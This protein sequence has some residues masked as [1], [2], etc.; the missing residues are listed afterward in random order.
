MRSAHN[1][2]TSA[3][4]HAGAGAGSV[5]LAGC[6]DRRCPSTLRAHYARAKG[7]T[8][9]KVR[10]KTAAM[11]LA[12]SVVMALGS[13][14]IADAT[15]YGRVANHTYRTLTGAD[16]KEGAPSRCYTWNKNGGAT[17]S[18]RNFPCNRFRIAPRSTTSYRTDVDGFEV[19]YGAY[20]KIG[21]WGS[22]RWV[23]G[24][25]FTRIRD[26]EIAVCDYGR[27]N[28]VYCTVRLD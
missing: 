6:A 18:P 9:T 20:V 3:R 15:P 13:A 7:A 17:Y 2:S 11:V 14:G 12:A 21:I 27:N 26:Y 19:P 1:N 23:P 28:N 4:P 22:Y 5:S 8:M 10:L 16:Y 24:G 25:T